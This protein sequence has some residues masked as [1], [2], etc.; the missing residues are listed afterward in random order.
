MNAS[1]TDQDL[2]SPLALRTNRDTSTHPNLL[3]KFSLVSHARSL[4]T[5]DEENPSDRS[6]LQIFSTF[7]GYSTASFPGN[8]K[9]GIYPVV[10][11]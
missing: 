1:K 11:R 8:C 9:H 5:V 3:C 7:Q 2:T 10:S 6:V 4:E